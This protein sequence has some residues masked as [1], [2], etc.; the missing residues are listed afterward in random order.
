[1]SDISDEIRQHVRM[2][3]EDAPDVESGDETVADVESFLAQSNAA[4][5]ARVRAEALRWAAPRVGKEC[6]SGHEAEVWL[7]AEAERLTRENTAQRA[8]IEAAAARLKVAEAEVAEVTSAID[9]AAKALGL[10]DRPTLIL[11]VLGLC[12]MAGVCQHGADTIGAANDALRAEVER[13][14]RERDAFWGLLCETVEALGCVAPEAAPHAPGWATKMREERDT[15]RAEVER[16]TRERDGWKA[17]ALLRA[18]NTEHA[19]AERDAVTA[20]LAEVREAAGS[21]FPVAPLD[22]GRIIPPEHARLFRAIASTP[23]DLAA[24]RDARVRAEALRC[25][26]DMWEREEAQ[27]GDGVAAW[28]RAE[29]ERIGGGR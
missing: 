20:T 28:L 12:E 23:A 25:A 4:H 26:A 3:A 22:H 2:L 14:T 8:W 15:L 13:L 9:Y 5:D 6:R 18:Q 17:D 16:L 19:Q 24:A 27:P 29:A 21:V 7:C 1:M 10:E 11:K